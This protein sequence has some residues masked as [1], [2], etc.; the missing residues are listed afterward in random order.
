[1]VVGCSMLALIIVLPL[2]IRN[3]QIYHD[4]LMTHM[5]NK[6]SIGQQKDGILYAHSLRNVARVLAVWTQFATTSFIGLFGYMCIRLPLAIYLIGLSLIGI[7]GLG[8]AKWLSTEEQKSYRVSN[9]IAGWFFVGAFFA[10]LSFSF[11]YMQPQARY[12]FY[13]LGPLVV[14]LG[15]GLKYLTKER[16]SRAIQLLLIGLLIT[17]VFAFTTLKSSFD[18]MKQDLVDAGGAIHFRDK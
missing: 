16:F 11:T 14:G 1:M 17:N 6:L 7:M 10:F 2:W 3:Y 5:F 15:F 18:R 13:A 4:P 12:L 8:W 9:R